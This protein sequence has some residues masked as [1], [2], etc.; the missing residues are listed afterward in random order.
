MAEPLLAK[1]YSFVGLPKIRIPLKPEDINAETI[2]AYL[3]MALSIFEQNSQKAYDCYLRYLT[4]HEILNKKRLYIDQA[5]NNNIIIEPHLYAIVEFKKGYLLGNPKEYAQIEEKKTDDIGYLNKY[6]RDID[7]S[8]KDIEAAEYIYATGAAGYFIR[9]RKGDF[10]IKTESPYEIF[11]LP[12][13]QFFKVYSSYVGE[14]ELFDVVVVEV[15][16]PQIDK[17]NNR[18][19]KDTKKVCGVYTR[20]EY[21]EFEYTNSFLEIEEIKEKRQPR[22]FHELPITEA[23]VHKQRIGVVE[24]GDSLQYAIDVLSSGSLDAFIDNANEIIALINMDIEGETYEEK[25]RNVQDMRKNGFIQLKTFNP[26]SPADIKTI[27]NKI[28]HSD[29]NVKY[30]KFIQVLYDVCGVPRQSGINA[31]GGDTGQ[32]RALGNGWENAYTI[33]LKDIRQLIRTDRQLLKRMLKICKMHKDCP[34]NEL[35][36][37]EIEIKYNIN[38]SDNLLIKTQSLQNLMADPVNMPAKIALQICGLT[39]DP[40]AVAKA[41]DEYKKELE[42]KI[43]DLETFKSMLK[44]Q[45]KTGPDIDKTVGDDVKAQSGE[46]R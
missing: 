15:E 29:V 1:K 26:Q 43:R 37:N 30:E 41:M 7:L 17:E 27:S 28:N 31:S 2:A 44:I 12:P 6:N 21:F 34:V 16:E 18:L 10:D 40:N 4:G 22:P 38:R 3:P 32:A 39:S 46:N 33:I 36:A 13:W 11:V 35:S 20:T 19:W 23:Y 5:D 8:T 24:I 9:P 42:T 25:A 14:E 45:A